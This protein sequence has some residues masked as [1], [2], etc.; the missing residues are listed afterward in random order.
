MSGCYTMRLPMAARFPDTPRRAR[1]GR[2][3]LAALGAAGLLLAGCGSGKPSKAQYV[4]KANKECAALNAVMN[5]ISQ[6]QVTFQRALVE[7]VKAKELANKSLH[8]IKLPAD[9]AVP[10]QW[11]HYRDLALTAAQGLLDTRPRSA[12]RRTL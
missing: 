3:L 10:G 2:T 1:G 7:S 4:A 6:Q 9:S 11:L 12:R 8:A 5:A